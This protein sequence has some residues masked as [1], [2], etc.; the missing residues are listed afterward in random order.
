[1]GLLRAGSIFG[2]DDATAA[3]FHRLIRPFSVTF[4]TAGRRGTGRE[5]FYTLGSRQESDKKIRRT[6]RTRLNNRVGS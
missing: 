4:W 2:E 1:M 3:T 6:G 5:H